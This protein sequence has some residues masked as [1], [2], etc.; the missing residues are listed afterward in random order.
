MN[1]A[2]IKPYNVSEL[3]KYT[4]YKVKMKNIPIFNI[5]SQ[6]MSGEHHTRRTKQA[7]RGSLFRSEIE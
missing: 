4:V 3:N 6:Q 1:E 2:F 7:V 5:Y